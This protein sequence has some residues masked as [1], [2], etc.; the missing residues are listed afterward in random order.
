MPNIGPGELILF[1]L[2][3]LVVLGP[4]RLPDVAQSLGKSLREFRKAATDI[5]DAT[6]LDPK[7]ETTTPTSA[8]APAPN[9]LAGATAPNSLEGPSASAAGDDGNVAPPAA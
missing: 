3:V 7:P 5:S 2:I 6:S 4:K 9:T 1:L 8:A